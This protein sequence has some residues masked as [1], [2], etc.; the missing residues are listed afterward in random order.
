MSSRDHLTH[1]LLV[2]RIDD[3]LSGAE[4][5]LVE[6]HLSQCDECRQRYQE[7]RSISIR[8]ESAVTEIVPENWPETWNTQREA[9]SRALESHERQAAFPHPREALRRFG[10]GMA[11]AAT[12]AA[13]A[14]LGPQRTHRV[15]FGAMVA[16]DAQTGAAFEVDGERF[17]ALPYSNPDLP[18]TAPHI[19][20]MQVPVSS[21]A[22]AGIIFEPVSN[23]VSA[24]DRS[25]LADVLLGL[26]GQ[27]LGVHVLDVE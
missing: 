8:V 2:R 6:S 11:I 18:L 4:S 23:Q 13:G 20:Q 22:D 24:P 27:P 21:L 26:D 25:V 15:K 16:Q 17:I 12:L 7:L 19:V 3:E 1:D 9:L 5:T 14:L 10:W